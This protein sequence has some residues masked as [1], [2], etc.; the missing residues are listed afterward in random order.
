M[1]SSNP[2]DHDSMVS[3]RMLIAEIA[4]EH[5]ERI[6]QRGDPIVGRQC[7]QAGETVARSGEPHGELALLVPEDVHCEGTALARRRPCP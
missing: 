5:G 1:D 2:A 3:G 6:G 4:D 7:S